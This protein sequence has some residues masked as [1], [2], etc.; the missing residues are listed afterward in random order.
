MIA[1]TLTANYGKQVDSSDT[2]KGPPNLIMVPAITFNMHSYAQ[3][4]SAAS[5]SPTLAADHGI[6]LAYVLS[7]H[8]GRNSGEDTFIAFNHKGTYDA[9]SENI[10]P[11]L[12]H[13]GPE[14]GTSRKTTCA[15]F[16]VRRLTP[17]ECERLQGFPDGWTEGQFDGTRYR[18]LG[19]AVAVPVAT[20]IGSRIMEAT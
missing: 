9:A 8:H 11:T 18:Q 7:A 10:A 17:L 16:G 13:G 15:A 2:K 6:G 3:D 19:N 20:W 5:V 1:H 12:T 4:V 14:G